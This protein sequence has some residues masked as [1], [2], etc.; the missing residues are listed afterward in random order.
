VE[1]L[2]RAVLPPELTVIPVG[3]VPAGDTVT[4][5]GKNFSPDPSQTIVTFSRVR[6]RVFAATETELRVE[7]PACLPGGEVDVQVHLGTMASQEATLEVSGGSEVLSLGQGDDRIFEASEG[8]ACIRLPRST[9]SAY[10]AVPLTTGTVGGASYTF[11]LT[12]ITGP[13]GTALKATPDR[14]GEFAG[15]RTLSPRLIAQDDWDLS[16]RNRE[17][18]LLRNLAAPPPSGGEPTPAPAEPVAKIGDT[19]SFKVLNRAGKF[20]TVSAEVHFVSEHAILYVDEAAPAGGFLPDDLSYLADQFEV[21]IHPTVT[22]AFGEESDLDGNEKV[23]ILFTP[24]VNRLTEPGADGYV[25]GFFFGLDLLT[26]QEGSNEGEVFYA[27]VPDPAGAEGPSISR[28]SLLHTVPAVLAHEF[29]H[30]VHFNQRILVSGAEAQD[31]LWL[32]EG[33]AQMAE[34]LVSLAAQKSGDWA[35]AGRYRAGNVSR[36]G[37]FLGNTNEVSLLATLPPGTLAERGAWW[38][39]LRKLYGS[40]GQEELLQRLA[41][42]TAAGTRNVTG[43][44]GRNWPDLVTEWAGGLFLDGLGVPVRSALK[45]Q[46]FNLRHALEATGRPYPL[47]PPTHG[48]RTFFISGS[49]WSSAPDY[50]I[51]TPSHTGGL[52]LNLAGP[53]GRPLDPA[54]GLRL[55]IVRLW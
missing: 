36:A 28:L 23:I 48:E 25:G 16:I 49:L 14:G 53:D 21:N 6:G 55:L 52:A 3:P 44:T 18:F 4:L 5:A 45:F 43:V 29:E 8:L 1:F 12:G 38:L 10:L 9:S 26:G 37:R 39:F 32:S 17:A 19:R 50:Y 22:G 11:S 34:D 13:G 7:V 42:S 24:V 46:G 41:S 40:D 54:A 51:I 35:E 15:T 2:A 33:M 27:L 47:Q 30:M 31:A 20:E